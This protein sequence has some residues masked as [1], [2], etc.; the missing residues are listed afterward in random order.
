MTKSIASEPAFF[1]GVP[2]F[3]DVFGDSVLP[4]TFSVSIMVKLPPT[5]I[6]S[7]D[8][9]LLGG[10]F[11]T[12]FD[13]LFNIA[14]QWQRNART[15]KTNIENIQNPIACGICFSTVTRWSP[16][17]SILFNIID[18]FWGLPWKHLPTMNDLLK[19]WKQMFCCCVNRYNSFNFPF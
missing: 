9:L 19:T 1:P 5:I 7:L 12:A 11:V 3:L 16:S 17:Y 10:N 18:I 8:L 14:M 15:T 6:P 13:F 2:A 4:F